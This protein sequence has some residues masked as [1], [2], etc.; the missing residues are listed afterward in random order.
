MCII[1]DRLDGCNFR[2]TV[3]THT[4]NSNITPTKPALILVTLLFGLAGLCELLVL[5]DDEPV[6]VLS[7]DPLVPVRLEVAYAEP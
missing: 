1:Q 3:Y 2:G 4:A 6:P 5:D 7:E